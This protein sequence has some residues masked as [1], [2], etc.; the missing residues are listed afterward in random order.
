[1][2]VGSEVSVPYLGLIF[3]FYQ[4]WCIA[5][6]LRFRPLRG[7]YFFISTLRNIVNKSHNAFP[8]PTWGLF[9][10]KC[11]IYVAMW[12]HAFPSPARGL[13]FIMGNI[14]MEERL[15]SFPS[16]ARG[17]FFILSLQARLQQGSASHFA[18]QSLPQPTYLSF[19]HCTTA[20]KA[21]SQRRGSPFFLQVCVYSTHAQ[22]SF[23]ANTTIISIFDKHR[24]NSVA[25]KI[26]L[27]A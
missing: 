5:C 8:S 6:K 17:L 4:K 14:S 1:M 9:L 25:H 7:A 27:H 12:D 19:F 23:D 22:R 3:C 15:E 21:V 20:A 24:N 16:P 10:C 2:G 26:I 13:F 18:A 11:V